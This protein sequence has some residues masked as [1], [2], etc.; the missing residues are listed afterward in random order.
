MIK[1]KELI[2]ELLSLPRPNRRR[3][4]EIV[5][6]IFNE[7]VQEQKR[8]VLRFFKINKKK[9]ASKKEAWYNKIISI[10]K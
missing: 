6:I 8:R 1:K 5:R 7:G 10:K 4:E 2:S 9:F 3:V